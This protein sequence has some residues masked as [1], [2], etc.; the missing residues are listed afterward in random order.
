MN[1]KKM[2]LNLIHKITLWLTTL[3]YLLASITLIVAAFC[4]SGKAV[5]EIY[6]S[7]IVKAEI[8][9]DILNAITYT[10][11]AIAVCDVGRY[12]IE[13]EVEH[14]K[15]LNSP[16]EAR[17]TITRFMVVIT[18]A[19]SLEGLVGVFEAGNKNPTGVPY[20]IAI[21]IYTIIVLI[22]LGIF[23]RLSVGTEGLLLRHKEITPSD[24]THK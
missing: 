14:E 23:Q 6:D 24:K 22:G 12:L 15:K 4:L 13:E 7:I 11:I 8:N 19:L 2:N 3:L 16:H 9:K 21:V 5:Y 10:V 1:K 18:I 17:R 20:P